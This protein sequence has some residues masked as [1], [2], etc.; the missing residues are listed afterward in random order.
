MPRKRCCA[1]RKPTKR[2]SSERAKRRPAR[3]RP[4]RTRAAPRPT[5]KSW[6]GC[7]WRA[8]CARR[9][10]WT[11]RRGGWHEHGDCRRRA[12]R[13]LAAVLAADPHIAEQ[14][15]QL[16]VAEY[17]ELP[18][19]FDEVEAVTSKAVV[20]DVLKPAGA[21]ADLKH[22]EGR[23]NT[24]VALDYH[25]RRG[26]AERAFAQADQVFEHTFRT[27]QVMHTPLEPFVSLAEPRENGI[28][29]HTASQ[30]PSFVRV[31]IAR[32]LGWPEN[33]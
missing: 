30:G 16:I 6:C 11:T 12:N 14:A 15:V 7:S 3:S 18:A 2:P 33:R 10:G 4:W 32:L 28:T 26:D 25:L 21:F 22:L 9:L 13:P 5:K 8:R 19:V 17:D 24:N 1:A 20:H 27:Q 31:E 29:I 23:K